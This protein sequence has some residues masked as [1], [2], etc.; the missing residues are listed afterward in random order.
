MTKIKE[1]PYYTDSRARRA[2][3][4]VDTSGQ[5]SI[6]YDE[7]TGVLTFDLTSSAIR[8]NFTAGTGVNISNG[9]ISI[10][11]SVGTGDT[12]TF[13]IINATTNFSGNLTGNVT[14]NVSGNV[15][16][17][18]TG[19]VS[20]TL[21]GSNIVLIP[22]GQPSSALEGQLAVADGSTWNPKSNGSKALMVYLDGIWVTVA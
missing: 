4:L 10:G 19:N 22:A 21:T 3:S 13:N 15:A 12:V 7:D 2:I 17:N 5:N 16:G 14:G 11:Q 18:L 6:S 9:Q 1:K 20:G 8:S